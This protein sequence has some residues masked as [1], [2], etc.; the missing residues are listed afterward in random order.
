MTINAK[1]NATIAVN[2]H[3][4]LLTVE[5]LIGCA[6]GKSAHIHLPT[7]LA[8]ALAGPTPVPALIHAAP[9]VP[10][11]VYLIARMHPLFVLTAQMLLYWVAGVGALSMLAASFCALAPV[12]YTH[13]T[14]PTICS[15]E[16]S[17]EGT[18]VRENLC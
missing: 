17:D 7:W 14:R 15:V 9:M 3:T 4:L 8:A 12:Y 2:D 18:A 11:G 10:P 5:T 16:I 6:F 13:L 1:V